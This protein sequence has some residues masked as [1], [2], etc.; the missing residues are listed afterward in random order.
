[1]TASAETVAAAAVASRPE[2]NGTA[3]PNGA[4]APARADGI[5]LLGEVAGSGYRLAP[6]LVRRADGQT[7]QLTPL[8]Y[9]LLQAIDGE[10]DHAALAEALTERSGKLA[11]ADDVRFLTEAKLRP[12]G[13]LQRPDGS[14]PQVAKVNPLLALR[15]KVIVSNP[16]VTGLIA[17]PF[18]ALFR[19]PIVLAVMAAFTAITGWIAFEEGLASAAHQ[20]I[21]EPPLLLLVFGLTL[22]SAAFHEIGHA[23]AARF[24]GARPGGMGVGLYLVWPAFYTD[25]TDAYRLGRRDRLRVDLGGLYFNAIFG[26]ATVGVW[27]AVGWDA[28]LLVF[29]AQLVQ[30]VRQLVPVVRFD[31][32]HVLADLVG[33]PDLFQHIKPTLLGLLPGRRTRRTPLKRWAR[34]V[35]TTWVLLVVPLL[36]GLLV[37]VVILLPRLLGTAWDSLGLHWGSVETGWAQRDVSA[38]AVELISMLTIVLPVLGLAYLLT[39]IVRRTSTRVWRASSGRPAMRTAAAVSGAL[40]VAGLTWAWWPGDQYRP[41]DSNEHFGLSNDFWDEITFAPPSSRVPALPADT[42]AGQGRWM[43]VLLPQSAASGG[44]GGVPSLEAPDVGGAASLEAPGAPADEWPFPFDSPDPPGEGDN[45]ALA[46]NTQD[47]SSVYDVSVALVWV[48]DGGP[49][50]NVN[51]AYALASCAGCE[52]VAVAFQAVIV[53]GYAHE[54]TPMNAAVA[55]NYACADCLT[56]ALA[57]QPIAMLAEL[58][59]DETMAQLNQVWA[60]LEQV[61]ATFELLPLEQVYAE[62]VAAQTTILE[63]LAV[64]TGAVEAGASVVT[65]GGEAT[66]TQATTTAE[67]P[68][69]TAESP[70]TT[71]ETS[72]ATAETST[73]T[74]SETST[75]PTTTTS[76]ETVTEPAATTTTEETSSTTDP[77]TTGETTT[78]TGETATTTGETTTTTTPP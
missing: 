2:G 34:A 11:T 69:T 50:D 70:T 38:I 23:A 8:L 61:S 75:E 67:S 35:V 18:T 42:G 31:G 68:T 49:V 58:P 73:T 16:A 52:T 20:A 60:Q 13:L 55:V 78:A 9:Q 26:V 27:A 37:L 36:A 48:T 71:A 15:W 32:Y 53:V 6:A 77:T 76:G 45:Q 17:A 51:E 41:I 5:E 44:E 47:G 59:S 24:S 30:M 65:D 7:V 4:A 72:T 21:Y 14:Q 3:A 56:Q 74:G 62:L 19:L 39:C 66:G 63:I 12:L 22:L 57:V 43:V 25:V 54:V 28:L 46:V 1:V 64:E 33:V 29:V 40:V 10:R